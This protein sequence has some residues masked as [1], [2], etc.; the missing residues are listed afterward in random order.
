ML[1]PC[2]VLATR[3]RG[4]ANGMVTDDRLGG[5]M[6]CRLLSGTP[7]STPVSILVTDR[8][9]KIVKRVASIYYMN[10]R[11][12]AC[13]ATLG[14]AAQSR[15]DPRGRWGR[16][17]V[18]RRDDDRCKGHEP[19]YPQASTMGIYGPPPQNV[20][21]RMPIHRRGFIAQRRRGAEGPN[22]FSPRLSL[23]ARDF[24]QSSRQMA[25]PPCADGFPLPNV[26]D[27]VP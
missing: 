17:T 4:S 13:G 2:P 7:E 12:G 5:F 24:F 1:L 6:C 25:Q 16:V 26:N 23:S 20:C 15:W 27:V 18:A 11:D 3:Q 8:S 22:P 14:F 19:I 21:F 10:A 9:G